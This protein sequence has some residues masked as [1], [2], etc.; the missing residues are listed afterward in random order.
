MSLQ[1]TPTMPLLL[2]LPKNIEGSELRI[3][4][5]IGM[6]YTMLGTRLL[7]DSTGSRTKAI[8]NEQQRDAGM[9][10]YHILQC[11]LQGSGI[12]PITWEKLI[13]VLKEIELKELARRIEIS[14]QR[15]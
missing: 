8:E 14:L 4:Q 10:N 9:I 6:S 5:E 13:Q 12:A 11:W 2:L 3:I 1:D 7:D 15:K